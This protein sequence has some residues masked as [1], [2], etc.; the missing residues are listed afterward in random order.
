MSL[1]KQWYEEN[2]QEIDR[3]EA[4][5]QK[6]MDEDWEM[7]QQERKQKLINDNLQNQNHAN[8]TNAK[9]N[10]RGFSSLP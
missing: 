10:F 6:L 9:R 2:R 1:T 4:Y 7:W 5:R 3:D 8:I